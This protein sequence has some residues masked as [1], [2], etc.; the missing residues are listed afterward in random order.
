MRMT[1]QRQLLLDIMEQ[2]NKPLSIDDIFSRVDDKKLNLSTVYRTLET[3][4]EAHLVSKTIINQ[5]QYYYVGHH[6]HYM[7]CLS[8][9]DMIEVDCQ[10][11]GNEKAIGSPYGFEVT[12]HDMTLYGYCQSCQKRLGSTSS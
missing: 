9:H 2:S 10:L 1:K 4:F 6:H 8:C 3:F 5:K 12:Y 11:E 7:V